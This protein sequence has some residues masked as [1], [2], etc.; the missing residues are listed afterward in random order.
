MS[1][2]KNPMQEDN[3][4]QLLKEVAKQQSVLNQK[5]LI[6]ESLSPLANLVAA[7]TWQSVLLV[8]ILSTLILRLVL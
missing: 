4:L 2:I 1:L 6:P 3:F 7:Y 5:R 8:A